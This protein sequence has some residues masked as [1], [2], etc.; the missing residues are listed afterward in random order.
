MMLGTDVRDGVRK[1]T[2]SKAFYA[3]AGAG[4]LAVEKLREMPGRLEQVQ[5]Q[6]RSLDRADLQTRAVGYADVVGARAGGAYDDRAHRG[7][8][9][10]RRVRRQ[11]AAQELE[12][13][14]RTTARQSRST[15]ASAKRTGA[16][17]TKATRDGAN[18][19]RG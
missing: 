5:G 14:T 6:L 16:A 4:E 9:A 2:G 1:L 8:N 15:A 12:T 13:E 11:V 18:R 19:P 10:V 17:A 3:V 7:R